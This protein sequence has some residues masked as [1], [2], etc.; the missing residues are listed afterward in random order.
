MKY[1]FSKQFLGLVTFTIVTGSSLLIYQNCGK[2]KFDAFKPAGDDT[3]VTVA[4]ACDSGQVAVRVENGSAVC[5]PATTVDGA[6]CPTGTYLWQILT[7]TNQVVCINNN[8]PSV[9]PSGKHLTGFSNGAVVCENIANNCN[10]T[11]GQNLVSCTNNVPTCQV[12]SPPTTTPNSSTTTQTGSS[13]TIVPPTTLPPLASYSCPVEQ[14]LYDIVKGQAVCKSFPYIAMPTGQCPAGKVLV[15]RTGNSAVCQSIMSPT[16]Q[17]QA[18]PGTQFTQSF[19]GTSI[20]CAS[21]PS[22]DFH[23]NVRVAVISPNL[24]RP[25]WFAG[26]LTLHFTLTQVAQLVRFSLDFKTASVTALPKAIAIYQTFA[27]REL[28]RLA[29]ME[30]Q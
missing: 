8:T 23:I 4:E 15:G 6:S 2:A 5:V 14:Y 26:R 22:E 29:Q 1:L 3:V 27:L 24:N 28:L 17:N 18:C 10:C 11:S 19:N 16:L 21:Q 13:T 7:A 9:C 20:V 30:Q 25:E 12:V